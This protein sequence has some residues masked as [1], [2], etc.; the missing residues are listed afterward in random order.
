MQGGNVGA[1]HQNIDSRTHHTASQAARHERKADE[2]EEAGAPHRARVAK[3][4]VALHA[5]LVDEVDDE[6]AEQRADARQ[7]VEERDVHL[8][9][10]LRVV[11]R[12]VCVCREDRGVEERPVRKRKLEIWEQ[13]AV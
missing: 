5:V 6:H 2:E 8:R 3:V 9:R 13:P 4:L 7:P 10:Q 11:E 12:R 1:R